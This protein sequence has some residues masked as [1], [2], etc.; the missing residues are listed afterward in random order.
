MANYTLDK[1]YFKY[2]ETDSMPVTHY[3]Y[4]ENLATAKQYIEKTPAMLKIFSDKF[5][6]YP[7]I[8]EK[9]GHAQFGWSG[10]MEHQTC[11]SLGGFGDILIAHE[12]SHQW[13]GDMVTCK[14]WQDIWLN[15]GFATFC[16]GIYTEA[17]SGH[18]AYVTY[19]KSKM[20]SA[21]SA[22]GSV[23]VEDISNVGSIFNTNRSYSKGSV[24]L[25]ML[26]GILGDSLFFQ[27][28]RTYLHKSDLAYNSVSTS[29][30]QKAVEDVYGSSL[31]YFFNEW[32]Y[33]KNY[34][35]YFISWST[36]SGENSS[37][38]T[39]ITVEQTTNESPSYFTM[40]VQIKLSNAVTDTTVTLFNDKQ[41]QTFA[42]T[43]SFKP[44]TIVFDPNSNILKVESTTQVDGRFT[45]NKDFSLQQNYPNPFN[46]TTTIVYYLAHAGNVKL[47][48]YDCLGKEVMTPVDGYTGSGVHEIKVN[49]S[50]LASGVYYY[51]LSNA[52]AK[53]V[54]SMM[55][56]K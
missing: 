49:A 54:K 13:F 2:S 3:I 37:Y 11:T 34:P 9:Y 41:S 46:P 30:F 31:D 27:A 43:T 39:S 40:P 35:K 20:S 21:V 45:E 32:I 23:Y 10:G 25:H 6:L 55:I 1:Q 12:L 51:S 28:M 47:S 16:E 5:G 8:K 17:I 24:I 18:D 26:R 29:D 14:T 22:S 33:G 19:M 50:S 52:T 42:I 56:L 44:A 38:I 53:I 36:L 15:E 4:P 48:I 7:F